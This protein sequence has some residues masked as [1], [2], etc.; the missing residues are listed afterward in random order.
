MQTS[1]SRSNSTRDNNIELLRLVLMF[2]IVLE[3][4]VG[5][6]CGIVETM[7]QYPDEPIHLSTEHLLLYVP[8]VMSVNCFVFISG[9]YKIKFRFKGILNFYMQ[10]LSVAIILFLVNYFSSF[11]FSLSL[12][13]KSIFPLSS[14]YWWFLSTYMFLYLVSPFLNM[15][16]DTLSYKQF[17]MFI[18]LFFTFNCLGGY[19]WGTFNANNGYSILNFMFLYLLAIYMRKYNIIALIKRPLLLWYIFSSILVIMCLFLQQYGGKYIVKLLGYNNP[20][21]I[22][23]AILFFCVFSRINVSANVCKFSNLTLGIYL[24]HDNNVI[25]PMIES[26]VGTYKF[27][28]WGLVLFALSIYILSAILE[29]LRKESYRLLSV[30]LWIEKISKK[31]WE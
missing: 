21:V 29:L 14:N 31:I 23:L 20:F 19:I 25:R 15:I 28:I 8:A 5:H 17:S 11:N 2:L 4:V 22:F 12:L 18:F 7:V 9:D 16:C 30:D 26:I 13:V 10:A 24:F 27:S 3:H 1:F 6:G